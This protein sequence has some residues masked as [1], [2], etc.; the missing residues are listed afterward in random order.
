MVE[1]FEKGQQLLGVSVPNSKGKNTN[2]DGVEL[3]VGASSKSAG[4]SPKKISSFRGRCDDCGKN[5][6]NKWRDCQKRRGRGGG[7]V[8]KGSQQSQDLSRSSDSGKRSGISQSIRF[9]KPQLVSATAV[10]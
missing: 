8:R 4:S 6:H 7:G 9:E 3:A 2:D 10:S 1:P 5:W